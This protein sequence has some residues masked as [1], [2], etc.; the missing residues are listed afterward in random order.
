MPDEEISSSGFSRESAEAIAEVLDNAFGGEIATK[1]EQV[2]RLV[3]RSRAADEAAFA[4]TDVVDEALSAE[5]NYLSGSI[6]D[7]AVFSHVRHSDL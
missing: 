4:Q 3:F 7:R 5:E 6:N 1:G 2:K